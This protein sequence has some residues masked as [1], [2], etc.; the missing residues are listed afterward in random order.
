MCQPEN[1]HASLG[2]IS[3][4]NFEKLK[5]EF[6]A[7]P[8]QLTLLSADHAAQVLQRVKSQSRSIAKT[9]CP[10]NRSVGSGYF[11]PH[12]T[13]TGMARNETLFSCSDREEIG[14][15]R[16][17]VHLGNL[18]YAYFAELWMMARS[19]L[20]MRRMLLSSPSGTCALEFLR[21]RIS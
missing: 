6:A 8:R 16:V 17:S 5:T 18:S 3:L 13:G 14:L 11:L 9:L 15:G 21:V 2:Q 7:K 19:P 10:S 1:L 12:A 20:S 4:H